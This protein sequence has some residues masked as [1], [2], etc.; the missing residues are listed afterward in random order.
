MVRSKSEILNEAFKVS[1]TEEMVD[2]LEYLA[3]VDPVKALA[4]IRMAMNT[5]GR[6][7]AAEAKAVTLQF[8]DQGY[9]TSNCVVHMNDMSGRCFKCGR[10]TP[11]QP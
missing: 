11:L 3:A 5:Y 7:M 1:T 2:R 8:S 6:E 4:L 9:G 10:S